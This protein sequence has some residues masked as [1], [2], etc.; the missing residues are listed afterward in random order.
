MTFAPRLLCVIFAGLLACRA[1]SGPARV[2]V[3]GTLSPESNPAL[4]VRD[5]LVAGETARVTV[6]TVGSR[7]CVAP[8]GAK[9]DWP[10]IPRFYGSLPIVHIVPF[11][12]R[13]DTTCLDV[14]VPYPRTISIAVPRE[15]TALVIVV[16]GRN[17]GA[18][19]SNGTLLTVT[20][21]VVV[22]R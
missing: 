14:L 17:E 19:P 13:I 6:T 18:E 12:W 5:T 1:P 2:R 16:Q 3:I 4:L 15:I 21:T 8:A 7:A 9:V 10:S 20:D 11:D 22:R